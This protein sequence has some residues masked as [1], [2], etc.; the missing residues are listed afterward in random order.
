LKDN[1]KMV[2]KK[3]RVIIYGVEAGARTIYV[4]GV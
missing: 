1:I 4:H 2:L 3:N